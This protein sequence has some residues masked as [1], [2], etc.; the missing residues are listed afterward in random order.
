MTGFNHPP[1]CH[2]EAVMFI[3]S[4]KKICV[5]LGFM[6]ES[7]NYEFYTRTVYS[8]ATQSTTEHIAC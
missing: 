3:S 7:T 4:Y 2:P 8:N 1:V 5:S 6:K